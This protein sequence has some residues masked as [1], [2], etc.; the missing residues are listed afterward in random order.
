MFES[1][2]KYFITN[3]ADLVSKYDGKALVLRGEALVGVYDTPLDAYLAAQRQFEPGTFMIQPCSPGPE[4][5]TV[6][7]HS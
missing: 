7:I 4:A 5:Y 1:E 3:Q 6:T 2:L